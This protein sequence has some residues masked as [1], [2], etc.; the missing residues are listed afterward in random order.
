M[1]LDLTCEHYKPVTKT[2]TKD[3]CNCSYLNRNFKRDLKIYF[4]F[5][6]TLGKKSK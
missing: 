3:K 1:K 5:V 2:G 6:K 4:S